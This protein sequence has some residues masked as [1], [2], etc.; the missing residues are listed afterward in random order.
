MRKCSYR[1]AGFLAILLAACSPTPDADG[2]VIQRLPVPSEVNAE[3]PRLSTGPDGIT[4]LSWMEPD[5][6]GVTLWYS[7][8]A[9]DGW[10]PRKAVVSG[11]DMFV[12]WAD[13][14][15]VVPL[16]E[17]HWAAHWLEMA[18]DLTYSYHVLLT[19]SFDGGRT[20]SAPLKI[21]RDETPTEHGVAFRPVGRRSC[22]LARRPQDR[23]GAF[24][25]PD[26]DGHDASGS[27]R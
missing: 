1:Y 23:F 14:P 22:N 6:D 13:L 21:H 26:R 3:G 20:W 5:E 8:L 15:S 2:N 11:K 17:D 9:G 18:G 25:R 24:R 7:M 12:N 16:D 19:Q 4:I 27:A 10:Q